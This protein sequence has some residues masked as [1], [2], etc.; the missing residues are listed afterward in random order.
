MI[1]GLEH[2]S[3]E[4]RLREASCLSWRRLKGDLINVYK[5]LKGECQEDGVSLFLVVPSGRTRGN[6]HKL[7]HRK[8]HLNMRKNFLLWG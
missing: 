5:Y 1:E 2:L 3:Y 7:E 6:E 4:D 8:L